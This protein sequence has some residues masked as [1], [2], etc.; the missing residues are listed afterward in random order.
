MTLD[1]NLA[2]GIST[3]IGAGIGGLFAYLTSRRSEH[4]NRIAADHQRLT[5]NYKGACGEIEA[6]HKLEEAYYKTLAPLQGKT[7]RQMQLD[8]R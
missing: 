8:M 1:S 2:I 5:R 6:F 3:A 7:P 4:L